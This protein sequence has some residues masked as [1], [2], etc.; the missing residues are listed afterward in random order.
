MKLAKA[1]FGKLIC[2]HIFSFFKQKK[3]QKMLKGQNLKAYAN[4]VKKKQALYKS[5]KS[6]LNALSAQLK[7]L[8][9]RRVCYLHFS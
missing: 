6:E 3:Q 4:E 7:S 5:K 8:S 1:F 9:Q 2:F